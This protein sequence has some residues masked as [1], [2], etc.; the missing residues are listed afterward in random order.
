MAAHIF[1]ILASI[2]IDIVAMNI[3]NILTLLNA[4]T[5]KPVTK[6]KDRT[7]FSVTKQMNMKRE[8]VIDF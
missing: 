2:A 4:K 5:I 7:G 3:E 6:G 1:A 8:A